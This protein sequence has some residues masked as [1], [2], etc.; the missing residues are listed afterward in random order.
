MDGLEDGFPPPP[1]KAFAH[2]KIRDLGD[3]LFRFQN[4]FSY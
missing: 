2:T 1:P 3:P 4:K